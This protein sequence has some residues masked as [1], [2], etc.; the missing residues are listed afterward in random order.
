LARKIKFLPRQ[1]RGE[2]G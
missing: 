1:R 2:A